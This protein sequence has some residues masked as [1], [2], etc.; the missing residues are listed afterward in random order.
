MGSKQRMGWGTLILLASG[1]IFSSCSQSKD[2][3]QELD[4][5]YDF[6]SEQC[7][8]SKSQIS[9]IIDGSK[10]YHFEADSRKAVMLIIQNHNGKQGVC[11]ST[12]ISDSVLLTAGHCIEDAAKV[13]AIFYTDVTCSSGYK[14][15]VHAILAREFKLHDRFSTHVELLKR[16]SFPATEENPDLAL[17]YLERSAPANYPIFK[18]HDRPEYIQSDLYLYGYGVTGSN[19]NDMLTLRKTIVERKNLGWAATNLIID[20]ENKSGICKGDSGG[21][22]LM[23]ENGEYVIA[24]VNSFV[25]GPKDDECNGV[26][27][28]VIVHNYKDWIQSTMAN[29]NQILK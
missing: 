9:G 21:A 1:L 14:R 13:Q 20:Q 11:T 16:K 23:K 6:F 17:V 29:W 10:V 15:N 5:T 2:Q 12:L 25:K 24:A 28:L 27:S 3:G 8:P 7:V 18:I 19:E 4:P 22:G 26:S